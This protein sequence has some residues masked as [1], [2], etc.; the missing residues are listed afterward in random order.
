VTFADKADDGV[1]AFAG[2]LELLGHC[3]LGSLFYNGIAAQGDNDCLSAHLL[4]LVSAQA[5]RQLY[6][7]GHSETRP[8]A[9]AI[10]LHK[11]EYRRN[12]PPFGGWLPAKTVPF[13]LPPKKTIV[14]EC[15]TAKKSIYKGSGR[16]FSP[17]C[18]R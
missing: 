10:P 15:A 5:K 14:K 8:K 2:V 4:P 1:H 12:R 18:S 3:A 17:F 13:F 9:Y 7:Y 11:N 16:S 6:A